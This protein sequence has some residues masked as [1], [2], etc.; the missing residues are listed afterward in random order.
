MTTELECLARTLDMVDEA[1][2]PK[3]SAT[4]N[5]REPM[6]ASNEENAKKIGGL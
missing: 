5:E 2:S 3:A 6:A 1:L 4:T